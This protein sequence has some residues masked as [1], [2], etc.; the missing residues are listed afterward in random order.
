MKQK[1]DTILSSGK[2]IDKMSNNELSII[3]RSLKRKEDTI[4]IPTKKTDMILLYEDWKGRAPLEYDHLE[5]ESSN[6]AIINNDTPDIDA[7]CDEN[8]PINVTM[9]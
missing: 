3:L 7:D 6:D 4:R 8:N 1:A 9:V 2:N 5:Q